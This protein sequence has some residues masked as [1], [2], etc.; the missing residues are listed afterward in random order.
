MQKKQEN[1]TFTEKLPSSITQGQYK[2][3]ST[4]VPQIALRMTECFPPL[5]DKESTAVL[6]V[7][8]LK[9]QNIGFVSFVLLT[10]FFA[11]FVWQFYF[12]SF[13]FARVRS[14]GN[15]GRVLRLRKFGNYFRSGKSVFLVG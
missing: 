2:I 7:F 3:P 12:G 15:F 13:G 5:M 11:L 10:G 14:N 1:M 9:R 4:A 8:P 6:T